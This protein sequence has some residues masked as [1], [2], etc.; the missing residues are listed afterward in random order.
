MMSVDS[1]TQPLAL[2]PHNTQHHIREVTIA[3][4]I[5][6]RADCWVHRSLTASTEILKMI[7]NASKRN[8]GSGI[9]VESSLTRKI[10]AYAQIMLLTKCYEIS[11]LI[12]SENYR[13]Q[14]IGTA[15]IQYLIRAV[16]MNRTKIIEI[17]VAETNIRALA[18]YQKLGFSRAYDLKL[19][20]GCIIYLRLETGD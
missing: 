5:P 4:L 9:V 17:G 2:Q 12:V 3:D 13:S 19:V 20:S 8:R 10:I 11:D 7:E 15:M 1:N 18:L 16:P 6:L 14:G